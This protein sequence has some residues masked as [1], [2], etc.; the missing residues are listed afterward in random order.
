MPRPIGRSNETAQAGEYFL[1][2]LRTNPGDVE[3]ILDY[4]IFLLETGDLESAKE[5]FHRLLEF[6]PHHPLALFHLGEM[7]FRQ[8]DIDRAMDLYN[9]SL[10]SDGTLAGPYY[11][12]AQ[13]ALMRGQ[14]QKARAYLISELRNA[15]DNP[16]VLVSAGIDVPGRSHRSIRPSRGRPAFEDLR[17]GAPLAAPIW[18]TPHTV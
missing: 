12:L 3:V 13:V 1:R 5:K 8:G 7:A 4:G 17:Y 11:R 16:E 15:P 6:A 9:Q 2:E 10:R 18:I 14:T